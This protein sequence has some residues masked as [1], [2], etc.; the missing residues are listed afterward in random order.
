MHERGRAFHPALPTVPI[1]DRPHHVPPIPP[2][3]ID[4]RV[5]HRFTSFFFIQEKILH[6]KDFL[7]LFC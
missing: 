6:Q 5:S 7:L 1:T 4:G 2:K 3:I